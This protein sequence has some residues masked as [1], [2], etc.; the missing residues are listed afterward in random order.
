MPT[1]QIKFS[2]NY[3]KEINVKSQQQ[4]IAFLADEVAKEVGLEIMYAIYP[5]LIE[6]IEAGNVYLGQGG[7]QINVG[8]IYDVYEMTESKIKDSYTGENLGN[9]EIK[10]GSIKITNKNSKF[11]VAQIIKSNYDLSEE[12][13]S[14]K[15]MVK[16]SK[17]A[18]ITETS[19]K[20]KR[21]I[22]QKW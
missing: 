2:S 9:V 6:K 5:I 17:A 14:E 4:P 13:K 7:N 21:K 16:P 15:F 8:D 3:R 11:S 20:E 1:K 19:S 18:E 22:D 12:F 10:V